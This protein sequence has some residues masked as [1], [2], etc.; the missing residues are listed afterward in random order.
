MISAVW[1]LVLYRHAIGA[2]FV[3]DDIPQIQQNP[4]LLTWHGTLGYFRSHVPFNTEFRGVAGSFY[5]PLFWL[6][7]AC[8]RRLWG[9]NASGFHATN[10]VLHWGNGLLGFVL[11]RRFGCSV[12]LAGGACLLWLGLPI[13]SEV[14]AWVSGRSLS[15]M[16]GLLLLSLLM[17]DWYLRSRRVLA[18]VL[19]FAAGLAALL[20][21][22]AS[23]LVVPLTFLIAYAR[24]QKVRRAWLALGAVAA[25]MLAVW[26][27]LRS[28]AGAEI[29]AVRPALLPVGSAF[30]KY[31]EW[32]LFPV[33]MSIERSTDTPANVFSVAALAALVAV[34]VF[35]VF[36]FRLRHKRPRITGGLAWMSIALL[37]FCG[38]VFLY[39]G[40]A[41]RYA[42]L[43]SAGLA[44]AIASAMFVAVRVTRLVACLIAAWAI[45]GAWRLNARV[46]DWTNEVSL[47]TASLEAT[48]RSAVLLYNLGSASA[49]AG[50]AAHAIEYYRRAIQLNPGYVSALVNLGNLYRAQAKYSEAIA[51]YRRAISADPRSPDAWIDLGNTYAESGSSK[52]AKSAYETAIRLKPDDTQAVI[53]LGVLLQRSGDLRAARQQYERAISIDPRQAAVYCD[54]GALLVQE[55][56][57]EAALKQFGKAIEVDPSYASAYFDLGVLYQRSGRNELAA[58]MYRKALEI[59]P[60][61]ERARTNLEQLGS[62]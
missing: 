9:L 23:V 33:H 2:P 61:Y 26:V 1:V 38:I 12:L 30:V 58:Q 59:K 49:E 55:G 32:I 41:E 13:N 39:Q 24:D 21:H 20:S 37:P 14:V 62:H 17:V 48:P 47:Y 60:D 31:V 6:S 34:A 57:A 40:M 18:L 7:L 11:L 42:Y 52:D 44:F 29:A 54:L 45:W 56:D 16:S 3:Y 28:L 5:R 27:G 25:G 15:L 8:D 10:L 4:A 46:L 51:L 22:E 35:L 50:D 19:Y 43:A 53:N 36:I